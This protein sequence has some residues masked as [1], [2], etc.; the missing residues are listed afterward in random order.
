M[1]TPYGPNSVF[2][3]FSR[4]N[5]KAGPDDATLLLGTRDSVPMEHCSTLSLVLRRKVASSGPTLRKPPI[6]YRII[7]AV[8]TGNFF[9]DPLLF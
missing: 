9:D 7:D 4:Y 2:R 1:L 8:L 3:K 5:P 6:V